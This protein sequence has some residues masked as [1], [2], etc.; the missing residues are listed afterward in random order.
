MGSVGSPNVNVNVNANI[1]S[2][3]MRSP[4]VVSSGGTRPANQGTAQPKGDNNPGGSE[5]GTAYS[6]T[7]T[8]GSGAAKGTGWA[9]STF[10]DWFR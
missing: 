2:P 10:R 9:V 1:D 7:D 8:L 6:V 5:S 4:N 3:R